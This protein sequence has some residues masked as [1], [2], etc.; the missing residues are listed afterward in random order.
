M[1]DRF[2]LDP[3][4]RPTNSLKN[5]VRMGGLNP[6]PSV[7]KTIQRR[8]CSRCTRGYL[9]YPWP[10]DEPPLE[11][12]FRHSWQEPALSGLLVFRNFVYQGPHHA[13]TSNT[14]V[15]SLCSFME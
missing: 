9:D 12:N 6:R 14:C 4:F 10:L 2:T 1:S 13:Y 11:F 8:S 15:G 5:L 7:Y 3:V